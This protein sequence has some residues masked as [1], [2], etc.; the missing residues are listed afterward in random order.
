VVGPPEQSGSV[1]FRVLAD[2]R[3]LFD[4]GVMRNRQTAAV[5]IP[6]AG[7]RQLRLVVTD[8]GD[9]YFSDSADWAAARVKKGAGD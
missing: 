6:L 7:V 1:V 4:S 5:D 2:D 9:G 3:L 8:A